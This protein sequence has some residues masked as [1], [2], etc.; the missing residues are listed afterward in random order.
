[1]FLLKSISKTTRKKLAHAYGELKGIFTDQE[2]WFLFKISAFLETFGW[3]VLI[4]GILFSHFKWPG[5]DYVLPLA[6]SIHGIFYLF[7]LF[8]VL[9]GHRSLSWG[10]WRFILAEL[11]S[12]V[13]YGAL[14]LEQWIAHERK[15]QTRK[16][17]PTH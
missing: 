17:I 12:V 2:A 4:V 8:I 3:T 6:G 7:Y 14:V 5:Y 13:P 15:Q 11:I 10:I 1:M 16:S 9:F